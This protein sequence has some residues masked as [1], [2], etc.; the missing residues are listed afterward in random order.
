MFEQTLQSILTLKQLCAALSLKSKRVSRLGSP[1]YSCWPRTPNSIQIP[2]PSEPAAMFPTYVLLGLEI[3]KID[4]SLSLPP[5][6]TFMG[7]LVAAPK[8]LI[9]WLPLSIPSSS[10]K[11]C[12]ALDKATFPS[13][14]R[15]SVA[16]TTIQ[17][18]FD[19]RMVFFV[20]TE[21]ETSPQ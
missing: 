14:S 15:L 13:T 6:T 1:G 7:D 8:F 10:I 18:W 12:A 2:E 9:H 16:C 19:S 20:T 4:G 3:Q 11:Q 17:R 21:P 5:G